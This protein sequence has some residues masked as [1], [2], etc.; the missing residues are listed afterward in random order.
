MKRLI[1]IAACLL[2]VVSAAAA[3]TLFGEIEYVE[4][5]VTLSRGGKSLGDLNIGDEVQVDDFIKTGPD[6]AAVI[7]LNRSTGMRGSLSV[8]PRSAV[9][10][11]MSQDSSG[12]KTTLELVAGQIGSKVA[13]LSGSP[14]LQVRT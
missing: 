1:V 2:T 14:T 12:S 10:V 6:G 13:K 4:G 3:Q 11:R 8:K 5:D 9:Y 7:A